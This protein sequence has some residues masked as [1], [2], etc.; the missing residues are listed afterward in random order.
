MAQ[1]SVEHT[2]SGAVHVIACPF[3]HCHSLNPLTDPPH[4]YEALATDLPGSNVP[5]TIMESHMCV[6]SCKI[7][8]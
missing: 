7:S 4:G 3:D 6:Y 2:A 5:F 1:K 8:L